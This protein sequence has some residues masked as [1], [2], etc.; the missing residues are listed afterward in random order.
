MATR[1]IVD[2]V[3]RTPSEPSGLVRVTGETLDQ[4]SGKRLA[5]VEYVEDQPAGYKKG[6]Y[7]CYY[8]EELTLEGLYQLRH[9]DRGNGNRALADSAGS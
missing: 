9:R 1:V 5:H 7:D 4:W 6:D 2:E 8:V 3:Y